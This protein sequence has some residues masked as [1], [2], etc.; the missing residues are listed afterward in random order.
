MIKR[1]LIQLLFRLL[2][3]E[4]KLSGIDDKKIDEW[5]ARQWQDAGYHEYFRRR[6][7]TLL[8]TMGSGID[9]STYRTYLGKRLELLAMLHKIELAYSKKVKDTEKRV[10]GRANKKVNK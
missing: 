5:L 3:P 10:K 6:D 8:K 7:L 2:D 1:F 9:D 4:I